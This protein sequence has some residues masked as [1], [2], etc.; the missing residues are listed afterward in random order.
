MWS[1]TDLENGYYKALWCTA[2]TA[3]CILYHVCLRRRCSYTLCRGCYPFGQIVS[4]FISAV[5][6]SFLPSINFYSY[7]RR[8]TDENNMKTKMWTVLLTTIR[9]Y[10]Q[11]R[12]N[13]L[14][15]D[16]S[17]C[18]VGIHHYQDGNCCQDRDPVRMEMSTR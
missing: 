7:S 17:Q 3:P 15:G 18:Q 9:V 10:Y 11:A 12:N 8:S 6:R 16:H 2:D 4:S 14:D 13:C 5:I 1:Y